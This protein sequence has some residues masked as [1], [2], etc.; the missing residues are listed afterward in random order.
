TILRADPAT[1]FRKRIGLM[2]QLCCFKNIAFGNELEPIRN[3]IMHRAFPLAIWITA[4]QTTVRLFRD[5]ALR[6]GLV[7][8]YKLMFTGANLLFR[9]IFAPYIEKLKNII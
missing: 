5:L 1:H 9:R 3:E 4:T 6:V 2:T 8:L 7:D